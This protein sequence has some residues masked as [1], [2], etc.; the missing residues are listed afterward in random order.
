[1]P[2]EKIDPVLALASFAVLVS[3]ALMLY[4]V[5]RMPRTA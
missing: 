5:V 1:V 3:G 4:M 2:L